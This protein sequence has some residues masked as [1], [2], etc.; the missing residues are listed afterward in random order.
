MHVVSLVT[1]Q[2]MYVCKFHKGVLMYLFL[3]FLNGKPE[4]TNK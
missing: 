1:L 4:V 2:V 3:D